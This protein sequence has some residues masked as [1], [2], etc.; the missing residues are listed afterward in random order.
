[1]SDGPEGHPIRAPGLGN[2][3]RADMDEQDEEDLR[4]KIHQAN[5][6]KVIRNVL[7]SQVVPQLA[8][9]R[10]ADGSDAAGPVRTVSAGQQIRD[11][12]NF[13]DIILNGRYSD[14]VDFVQVQLTRGV[15]FKSICLGLFTTV[16]RIL[17]ELWVADEI[18]FVDVTRGLGKLHAL[19]HE[20]AEHDQR[21][22]DVGDNTR[23][24]LAKDALEQHAFGLLLVSEVFRMEGWQVTGGPSLVIGDELNRIIHESWFD[25]I[26]LSASTEERAF[27]LEDAIK[28][29]RQASS[30]PEIAV[31]VGGH[32]F[33][34]RPEISESIG[35]DD[36]AEDADIAVKKA[37]HL[38]DKK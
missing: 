17:G 8:E 10:L 26:G 30:N 37:R 7:E 2:L 13:Q 33:A 16:A 25:V 6:D 31:L 29:I 34:E 32:G 21:P 20:F 19:V 35:A 12:L 38:T 14:A 5:F 24:V 9:D 27:D 22:N 23:I 11:N 18:S 4:V 1:M 15:S 28:S 3:R 36:V